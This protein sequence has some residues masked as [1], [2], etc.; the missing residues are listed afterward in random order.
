MLFKMDQGDTFKR[1]RVEHLNI[2]TLKLDLKIVRRS[3][4]ELFN[5][6]Y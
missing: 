1:C 3:K 4:L 5:Q 6:F 2:D